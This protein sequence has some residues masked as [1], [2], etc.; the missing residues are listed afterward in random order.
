MAKKE[1]AEAAAVAEKEAA[2]AA[3]KAKAEAVP[4]WVNAFQDESVL[5]KRSRNLEVAVD[6]IAKQAFNFAKGFL[7]DATGFAAFANTLK[8]SV[9]SSTNILRFDCGLGT[10]PALPK[11]RSNY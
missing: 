2:A 8:N 1:A 3:E 5:V 6:E 10:A 7:G 11:T 4:N 9:H